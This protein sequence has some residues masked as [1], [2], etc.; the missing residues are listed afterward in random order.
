MCH[1]DLILGVINIDTSAC[2]RI[3]QGDQSSTSFKAVYSA[4][5]TCSAFSLQGEQ[6]RCNPPQI[7][8]SLFSHPFNTIVEPH[9]EYRIEGI[10]LHSTGL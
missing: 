10:L 6:N 9:I 2:W 1:S 8:D 5:N 4:E 7:Q 3:T